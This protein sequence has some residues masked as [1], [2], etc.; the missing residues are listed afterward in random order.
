[1]DFEL[2][3]CLVELQTLLL[4]ILDLVLGTVLLW[5]GGVCLREI[6]AELYHHNCGTVW[7]LSGCF[8]EL[9]DSRTVVQ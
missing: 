8:G 6:G 7:G 1:M 5:I 2:C 9:L 4:W 3:P